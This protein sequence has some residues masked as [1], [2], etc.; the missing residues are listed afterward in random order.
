MIWPITV[1]F[2]LNE[3]KRART[4]AEVPGS[5]IEFKNQKQELGIGR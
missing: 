2:N 5:D 1:P 4:I 3:S